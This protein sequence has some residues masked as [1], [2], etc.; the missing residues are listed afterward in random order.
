MVTKNGVVILWNDKRLSCCKESFPLVRL[1]RRNEAF[2]FFS[3]TATEIRFSSAELRF[4]YL[5]LMRTNGCH[6]AKNS[7]RLSCYC[8]CP[9]QAEEA[10]LFVVQ[11]L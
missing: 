10:S 3:L 8:A 11:W 9:P 6:A 1:R 2:L 7:S 5:R 4:S